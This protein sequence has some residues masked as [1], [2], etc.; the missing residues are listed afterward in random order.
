D[1]RLF[2]PEVA[3]G[4]GDIRLQTSSE[5]VGIS[6]LYGWSRLAGNVIWATDLELLDAA[7]A[8]AKGL[9]ATEE[10]ETVAASFAVGL[11]EG[12]VGHLG[13]IWA[14]GQLLDARNVTF[15]FYGG[16]GTQAP[17]SFIEAKQGSG[18]APAYRGLAYI[19]FE[20]LDLSPFGNR[21]PQI[22]VELCRAVGEL[23]AMIRSVCVI[24]GATEYGY[25]PV[26]RVR[27]VGMGATE[28]ENIHQIEGVADWDVSIDELV[29][30]CPNLENVALVVAW[31]GDD[32]RCSECSIAPRVIDNGRVIKDA[33]WV[34]SGVG[35]AAA[36]EVSEAD[37]GPAYGGTPSD[38]AVL[39][40]IADLKSRGLGVTLYPLAMMDIPAENTLPDPYTG[41]VGQPA[42]PWRGRITCDPAPGQV[43][44]PDMSGDAATQV[45]AFMGSAE[46]GDFSAGS[47][48]VN[49]SGDE[50]F[51]YRRF[52]LHYAHL[53][54]MA[55][56]VEAFLIGSELRGLTTLRTDFRD[57]PFVD[58][59]CALAAD[60][61]SVLGPEPAITYG[62]DW[63]EYHG[64]QPPDAPGDKLFH[65]DALWA[66]EAI[67]AVGIDNYMPAADWRDG[68]AH[69]DRLVAD[70]P[71]DLDYL[72]ANISG[73]EGFDWFYASG[74]D[75]DH[76]IRTPITDSEYGE[77]W[78]WRFKDIA[79]WWGNAHYHR[80]D[81]VRD[82]GPTGWVGQGKPIWLTE[83]GCGAVRFG[84][85]QP[86]AF[87]DPKSSENA[88]PYY[89]DGSADTAM[90]RALLLAHHQFWAEAANNP[91]S[92]EYFGP[93]VDA[94]RLYLWAWDARPFPAFP[95][96]A[97]EWSDASAHATGHWLNGRLGAL[98]ADELAAA[99]LADH[100]ISVAAQKI[101]PPLIDGAVISRPSTGR[102]A[103]EPL[104]GATMLRLRVLPAA[105]EL[106]RLTARPVS[107]L[108][109]DD[110][111][112]GDGPVLGWRH[113]DDHDRPRRL[114]LGFTD[115]LA[116]YRA[117]TAIARLDTL[118]GHLLTEG[119]DW[120]LQA[121][122]AGE[123][124]KGLLAA[125]LDSG[126]TISFALP[127]SRAAL[128]VGDPVQL[129]DGTRFAIETLR[130]G[131][132]REI[133]AR[134]IDQRPELSVIVEGA[135]AAPPI[136]AG[137]SAPVVLAA[138]LPPS[139]ASETA[140]RL[141]LAAYARPWPGFVRVRDE[142]MGTTLAVL[143][144]PAA[145]GEFLTDL[146]PGP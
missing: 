100:G 57:F 131:R 108:A 73:G 42:Y 104:M 1:Q 91:Q 81:G 23:E 65:L 60:V 115:R 53:A 28:P 44:T 132:A 77:P 5:G 64:L 10:G 92:G 40:A 117:G 6:R 67:T 69:L 140:C 12:E 41:E 62:A 11:C 116:D 63:S 18:N 124:A 90:Q 129:E 16:N 52:I 19:V 47:G 30:L 123:L 93:M 136:I 27:L 95:A 71:H 99:V 86:N 98:T 33:S 130:D 74:Y 127:P 76:Q 121:A 59:L 2:A 24:P 3:P 110:L 48:T 103:L 119:A 135:L 15:R 26:P 139:D 37:G 31:F 106:D 85:N 13:R 114:S 29:A 36:L 68:E 17:D 133:E 46:I 50:D 9:G 25:D 80:V 54:D 94:G 111:V 88:R 146:V 45:D 61:R 118:E 70:I 72:K 8:G 78:V 55:G 82:A 79:S 113:G 102:S 75:R 128:E 84:A 4:G 20:R 141:I 142:A 38:A 56:G 138:T 39:A 112:K 101:I 58:S 134:L 145:V 109:F 125:R 14:D 107:E 97:D 89:S 21:I 144:R 137:E 35:R 51:G 49:F 32:L 122:P 120:T 7:G 126:E 66:H 34:V 96:R 22:T 105:M 83:V 87:A 43:G 143:D